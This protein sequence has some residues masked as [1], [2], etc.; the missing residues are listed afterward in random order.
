M[1]LAAADFSPAFV[2]VGLMTLIS[3]VSFTRLHPNEGASLR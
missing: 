2:F 3:M 1:Q